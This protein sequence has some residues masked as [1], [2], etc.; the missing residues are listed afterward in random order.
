MAIRILIL[1]MPGSRLW[2]QTQPQWD[3]H[4]PPMLS[5]LSQKFHQNPAYVFSN[6]DTRQTN[7]QAHSRIIDT[8]GQ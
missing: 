1:K 3:K 8:I 6:V 7:K 4:I 5:D 2:A